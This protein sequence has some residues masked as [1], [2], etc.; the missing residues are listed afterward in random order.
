MQNAARVIAAALVASLLARGAMCAPL[1]V[2]FDFSRS[3][4]GLKVSIKG[5]PLNAIL[6]TGVDPSLVDLADAKALGLK[7]N[8]G[9]AGEA[10]GF[11]DGRG[12]TVFPAEIAGLTIGQREF[13]PFDALASDMTS[14]SHDD[15]PKLSMV[16]GYSFLSDK[17]VL[18]DYVKDTLAILDTPDQSKAMV[19]KC[20]VRWSI[21]LTTLESYPVIPNF[22]FG[23]TVGPV[24]LDTGSNGGI[25]LFGAAMTLP[26]MKANLIH[27]GSTVRRGARGASKVQEFTLN[28]SV[29]FGP[30]TQPPGETVFIHNQ[31]G[32]AEKRVA[33]IG[34][35]LLKDLKIKMLLDYRHRFMTFYGR[36]S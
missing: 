21:P 19:S 33:N 9:D 6:D 7:F 29:G 31:E 27:V 20:H 11:G 3:E 12:M 5:E 2:P 8:Q 30:F 22:R 10:G 25:G 36:C 4:L 24:T 18:I 15:Q 23:K 14:L 34:N 28:E 16:L 17:I 1:V 26:G 13:P 32:A 35:A